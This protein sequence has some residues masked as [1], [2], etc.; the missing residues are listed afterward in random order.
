LGA[1]AA[2]AAA[3]AAEQYLDGGVVFVGKGKKGKWKGR[4]EDEILYWQE[5][6]CFCL[7]WLGWGGE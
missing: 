5:T 6:C 7:G 2:A 3:A 1:C 4:I